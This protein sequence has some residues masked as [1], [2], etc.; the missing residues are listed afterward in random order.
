MLFLVQPDAM[1]PTHGISVEKKSLNSCVRVWQ[2][3]NISVYRY[4]ITLAVMIGAN[5]VMTTGNNGMVWWSTFTFSKWISVTW[6]HIL[7]TLMIICP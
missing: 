6:L 4:T 2:Q 1:Q 7:Y 5:F 3:L